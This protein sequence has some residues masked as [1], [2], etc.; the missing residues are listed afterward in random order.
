MTSWNF[1]DV[2]EA[3]AT[4]VPAGADRSVAGVTRPQGAPLT[5]HRKLRPSE[6]GRPHQRLAGHPR[7]LSL[8]DPNPHC[9]IAH[10]K[11]PWRPLCPGDPAD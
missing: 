4:R 6:R 7:L 2:Y 3:V 11:L 8:R 9:P 1:A 10:R 5:R